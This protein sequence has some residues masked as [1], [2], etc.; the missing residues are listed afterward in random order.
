MKR[1][2]L[3]IVLLLFLAGMSCNFLNRGLEQ[4]G[5]TDIKLSGETRSENRPVSGFTRVQ[6]DGIGDLEIKF[7][8]SESLVVE[9]DENLLPYIVTEVKG[10][11]LII[12]MKEDVRIINMISDVNYTLTAQSLESIE[13]NGLGNITVDPVNTEALEITLDGSG[14]ITIDELVGDSLTSNLNGLGSLTINGGKVTGQ[15]VTLAGAGSYQAGDMVSENAAISL[16]GLGSATVWVTGIL[17]AELTGAGSLDYYGKP[18]A[19]VN[20]TGLG[21]INSLGEK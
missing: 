17:D 21:S 9:A 20:D 14:S 15:D 18:Q 7:G 13:L 16:T 1:I 12:R 6:L 3:I 2:I 19:T 5:G 11:T 8:N 4:I 10:D